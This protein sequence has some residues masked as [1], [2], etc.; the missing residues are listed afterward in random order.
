MRMRKELIWAVFAVMLLAAIPVK[1]APDPGLVG[2]WH[3]DTVTTP[4]DYPISPKWTPDSSGLNNHGYLYP[5]LSEPTLVGGKFGNALSFDGTLRYVQVPDSLSLNIVGNQLTFEAWIYPQTQKQQ[6]ILCKLTSA[7][8]GYLGYEFQLDSANRFQ[9]WLG[10]TSQTY[11]QWWGTKAVPLNAW[12]H[13][14]ATYDG[15]NVKIYINGIWKEQFVVT[16]NIGSSLGEPLRLGVW[17]NLWYRF[18]GKIDEVRVWDVVLT[19]DQV[20]ASYDLG[21][22]TEIG[23]EDLNGDGY[24]DV[25]F[26]SAFYDLESGDTITVTILPVDPSIQIDVAATVVNKVTP[27]GT[28]GHIDKGLS[29]AY[30]LAITVHQDSPPCKSIHIWLYLNT[31]DHLGVNAQFLPY[32]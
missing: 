29:S 3:L 15:I 9:F 32:G 22:A 13:V 4:S 28:A 8:A 26:T 24:P 1:A 23:Q 20:K 27:K 5:I 10:G 2:L 6:L 7:A 18:D 11:I 14:A 21:L 31:G 12:T 17:R 30:S 25:I 19:A 16:G